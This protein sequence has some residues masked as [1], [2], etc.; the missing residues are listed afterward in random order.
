MLIF[1]F[2]IGIKV[3][4]VVSSRPLCPPASNPS[5]LTGAVDF[6]TVIGAPGAA[7]GYSDIKG[8]DW[9]YGFNLG[10]LWEP[11]KQTRVGVGFTS[12]IAHDLEGTAMFT[13]VPAVAALR[14]SFANTGAH[15]R[16]TT[17]EI[18]D[19]S[20]YHELS[21]QWAVMADVSWTNWSR[22]KNLI[23]TYDNPLRSATV[24]KESWKDGYFFALGAEYKASE[25]LAVRAGVAYDKAPT[26]TEERTPRIPD[27]DRIWGSL[28]ATYKFNEKYSVSAAYTHIWGKKADVNLYDTGSTGSNNLRGNLK[29]TY[30]AHVDIVALQVS[31]KF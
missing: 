7:D 21:P 20:V 16:V 25:Q 6:G 26:P 1:S 11:T 28:G 5:D 15:A 30:D 13:N 24:T 9:G 27:S 22:F 4:V 8:S 12:A 23:I 2:T 31:A 3:K 19:I 18:L 10:F 14:A 29:G 17:P